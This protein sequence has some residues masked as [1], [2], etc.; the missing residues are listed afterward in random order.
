[1]SAGHRIVAE[2]QHPDGGWEQ[3][4][5]PGYEPKRFSINGAPLERGDP[6]ELLVQGVWVPAIFRDMGNSSCIVVLNLE[7]GYHEDPIEGL[8][9]PIDAQFRSP[10]AKEAA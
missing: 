6:V 3:D 7:L 10:A 2:G 1:M 8:I 4:P 9:V 5:P